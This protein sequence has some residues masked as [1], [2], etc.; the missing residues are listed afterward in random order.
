MLIITEFTHYQRNNMKN[1]IYIYIY[2]ESDMKT[3]LLFFFIKLF[4]VDW[5]KKE[6]CW[7]RM[8]KNVFDN[9]SLNFFFEIDCLRNNIQVFLYTRNFSMH[10]NICFFFSYLTVTPFFAPIKSNFI[11]SFT[12]EKKIFIIVQIYWWKWFVCFFMKFGFISD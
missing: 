3:Y 10:V 1:Y 2:K 8:K 12:W 9:D 6:K 7:C 5:L 11:I 4:Q